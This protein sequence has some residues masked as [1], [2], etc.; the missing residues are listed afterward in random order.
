MSGMSESARVERARAA[1]EEGAPWRARDLLESHLEAQ[2]DPDALALLGEVLHGM[3][4]LPAAGAV[5]FAG[6]AKGPDVDQAVAAWRE[7]TRDDFPTM[8]RSLPASVRADP[9]SARLKALRERARA[10]DATLDEVERGRS[11]GETAPPDG[12][13][14]GDGEG[15]VDGN[16]GGMDAAQVIAWIAAAAFVA[17]GL[18]GLVTVLQWLVPG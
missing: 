1:V 18:I 10:A 3:G 6:G 4:D 9:Q 14:E 7:R 12:A 2:W 17:C 8:W 15:G 13:D 11:P 16:G 5:W